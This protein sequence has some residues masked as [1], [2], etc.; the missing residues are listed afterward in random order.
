MPVYTFTKD[1]I[2]TYFTLQLT[3]LSTNHARSI[4]NIIGYFYKKTKGKIT[5]ENLLAVSS[6]LTQSKYS[7]VYVKKFYTYI[8]NFIKFLGHAQDNPSLLNMTMYMRCPKSK[9]TIKLMTTRIMDTAD[10]SNTIEAIKQAHETDGRKLNWK[11]NY[12]ATILFLSYTGQR[13]YTTARLTVKQLKDALANNPPVLTVESEQDKLKMAHYVP[14]HPIHIP[15]IQDLIANRQ[16]DERV[17]DIFQLQDWLRLHPQPLKHTAGKF[18]I[19]DLRKFFEQKSDEIGFTDANKNF[20][21][22]HGVSSINWQSYKAFLPEN[23][24]SRYIACW[25]SVVIQ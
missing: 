7:Y 15:Y 20:I 2:Q 17:F 3:G 23:V 25:G 22:S 16:D 5:K 24:Y 10:I 19:K 13:S 12:I 6:E 18:E 11:K 1:D 21:M 14:L 9:R 4:R 8:N